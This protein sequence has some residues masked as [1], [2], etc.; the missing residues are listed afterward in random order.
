MNKIYN[1]NLVNT[2]STILN[3]QLST[4]ILLALSYFHVIA[5][6]LTSLAAILFTPFLLY[7]LFKEKRFGWFTAFIIMI[8]LPIIISQIVGIEKES[9]PIILMISLFIFYFYCFVIKYVVSDWLKEYNWSQQ[10]EEQKRE[11][12]EYQNRLNSSKSI[13]D[14]LNM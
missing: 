9:F 2:F 10:L 4:S 1:Y 13:N 3:Y 8:F 6:I 14:I 7:V 5:L 11:K 12:E